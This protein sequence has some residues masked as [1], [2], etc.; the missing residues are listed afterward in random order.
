MPGDLHCD[1]IY[2]EPWVLA[3]APASLLA[4]V[5]EAWVRLGYDASS[6]VLSIVEAPEAKDRSA[7]YPQGYR[8]RPGVAQAYRVTYRACLGRDN[9]WLHHPGGRAMRLLT[10]LADGL[11]ARVA[12]VGNLSHLLE[13]WRRKSPSCGGSITKKLLCIPVQSTSECKTRGEEQWPCPPRGEAD[14]QTRKPCHA[15]MRSRAPSKP[16]LIATF[17]IPIGAERVEGVS[18]HVPSWQAKAGHT[19]KGGALR[20][21]L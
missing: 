1:V 12:S 20:L 19:G 6:E 10:R 3:R 14:A 21:T 15:K 8:A 2:I 7:H 18:P 4:Y 9:A 13:P 16:Y 17:L 11:D 5:H